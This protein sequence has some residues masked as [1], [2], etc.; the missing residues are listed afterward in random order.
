[1]REETV[2]YAADVGKAVAGLRAAGSSVGGALSR[3]G[4]RQLHGL[5]GWLPQAPRRT[6]NT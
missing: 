6:C 3:Y 5:T 1:M 2:K 4:Q